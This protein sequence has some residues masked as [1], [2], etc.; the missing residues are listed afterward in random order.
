MTKCD[1]RDANL[2]MLFT[3]IHTIVL[4][5]YLHFLSQITTFMWLGCEQNSLCQDKRCLLTKWFWWIHCYCLHS[6]WK[7]WVIKHLLS[8]SVYFIQVISCC[9]SRRFCASMSNILSDF[10]VR[11]SI[12]LCKL[13][14]IFLHSHLWIFKFLFMSVVQVFST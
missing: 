3:A 1:W 9:L 12:V 2:L 8:G 7:C 11:F 10:I 13:L 14:N 4:V 5:K 6:L